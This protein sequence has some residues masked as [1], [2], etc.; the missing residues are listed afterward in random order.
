MPMPMSLEGS[1]CSPRPPGPRSSQHLG[2][3][4]SSSL[5]SSL[6]VSRVHFPFTNSEETDDPRAKSRRNA[7]YLRGA[8]S[9]RTLGSPHVEHQWYTP[10]IQRSTESRETPLPPA[11]RA[12]QDAHEFQGFVR[13]HEHRPVTTDDATRPTASTR[14][15]HTLKSALPRP[16]THH[17]QGSHRRQPSARSN[18]PL[19][20]P[21]LWG[22]FAP[23]HAQ[24]ADAEL[25]SGASVRPESSGGLH[26][27]KG[28]GAKCFRFSGE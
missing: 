15:G 24:P 26:W 21:E 27:L 8:Q 25:L 4:C 5:S 6:S 22:P 18:E 12:L 14:E 10:R 3:G 11:R 9:S 16:T 1:H 23:A 17:A 19:L 13:G 7:V 20:P 2:R 28:L